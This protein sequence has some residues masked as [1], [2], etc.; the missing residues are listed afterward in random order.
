MTLDE[1]KQW[2]TAL[3]SV[4]GQLSIAI[5]R[6]AWTSRMIAVC[7]ATLRPVLRDMEVENLRNLAAEKMAKE[8][9]AK[10]RPERQRKKR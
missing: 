1:A 3:A 9:A 10:P 5:A 4:A 8:A 2:H 7:V 6:K